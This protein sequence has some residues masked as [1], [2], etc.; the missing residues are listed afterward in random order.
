M[1]EAYGSDQDRKIILPG[2]F[3]PLHE[4]HI[5]LLEVAMRYVEYACL[6]NEYLLIFVNTWVF[7]VFINVFDSI[8][9]LCFLVKSDRLCEIKFKQSHKQICWCSVCGGGYPCFELSAVNADK[10]PLSVAQIKD[11]VKQFEEAGRW[12]LYF[13]LTIYSCLQ[14]CAPPFWH[15]CVTTIVW[16]Q[17]GHEQSFLWSR[18]ELQCF[19]NASS[20][21]NTRAI[22]WYWL[23]IIGLAGKTVIISNQ[24]YFYKKAELFPGSSFVIGADTA[25]RLVN[26]MYKLLELV[27]LF[28]S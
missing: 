14:S 18:F 13:Q 16:F 27:F 25:A 4:G 2:S 9:T 28:I 23:S 5:K 8:L 6:R 12:N 20:C 7:C 19:S 24:P 10:P 15:L 11:R 17:Q 26:V 21:S 1:A 22:F 3:N